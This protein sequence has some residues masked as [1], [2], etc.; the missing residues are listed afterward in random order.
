MLVSAACC[1]VREMERRAEEQ[2]K[3]KEAAE[4][5]WRRQQRER[6]AM[7]RL[8]RAVGLEAWIHP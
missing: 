8:V 3:V 2:R 4:E 5:E 6:E 1:Q 7:K